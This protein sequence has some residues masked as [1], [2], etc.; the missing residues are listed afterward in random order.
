MMYLYMYSSYNILTSL[1]P[2]LVDLAFTLDLDLRHTPNLTGIIS[3]AA[4]SEVFKFFRPSDVIV[5]ALK[6]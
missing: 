4:L 6:L 3:A 2:T 5:L 1:L